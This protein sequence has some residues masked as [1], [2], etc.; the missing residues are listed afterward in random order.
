[1]DMMLSSIALEVTRISQICQKGFMECNI[2]TQT[3]P[4]E[5]EPGV[6]FEVWQTAEPNLF[7]GFRLRSKVPEQSI[8]L[9][10]LDWA[11]VLKYFWLHLDT[12]STSTM[13]QSYLSFLNVLQFIIIPR[14]WR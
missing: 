5:S 12:I 7:C 10:G 3:E 11:G 4:T 2:W 1:M 6:Q 13:I 9:D 8:G 14:V